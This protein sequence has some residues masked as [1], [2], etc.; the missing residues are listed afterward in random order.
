MLRIITANLNGIRS[1][2]SKGFFDWL[3]SQH[4]DIVCLQELKAQVDQIGAEVFWPKGYRCYYEPAER[5]GYSGVGLYA[6]REPD[7]VIAGMGVEEFD[8]EGRY[9]EARFG[10]LSVVSLYAPSGSSGPE[11]QASKDRF[12]DAFPAKMQ[13][14]KDTGRCVIICADSSAVEPA[15]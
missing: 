7:D 15:R 8:R 9:I 12:L 13:E 5:K 6:R 2:A 11:R 10:N 1:A 3:P 4:A 14:L